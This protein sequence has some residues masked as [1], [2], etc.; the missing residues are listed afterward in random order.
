VTIEVKRANLRFYKEK[1]NS[2]VGDIVLVDIDDLP[3]GSSEEILVKCDICGNEKYLSYRKYNK[4]LRNGGYYTCSSKCSSDKKSR[5]YFNKT[6]FDHPLLNP[7]VKEKK[8]NTCL[9]RYGVDNPKKSILI[10]EKSTKTCLGKY[11]SK[12]YVN[13]EKFKSDMILRYGVDNPMRSAEINEK[14]I[15]TGFM[16]DEFN[17]I[18]YQG[19]YELNFLIHCKD[20]NI[21]VS[22]PNFTIGYTLDG[23]NKK[24]LPDFYIQNL[25]LI[26]EIKST[27][28]FNLHYQKNIMKKNYTIE[29]GYNYIMIID[30]DY[31]EF[32]G[33]FK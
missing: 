15:K 18:K 23:V 10:K 28:Y 2:C 13:S 25:N 30:K 7:T 27:Y 4:N 19:K 1:Y 29:S 31:S 6:G 16:I 20:N 33:L 5:T 11:G 22:K 26:I 21:K 12:N 17:L 8:S 24:Y 3:A 9:L 32:D 14:R